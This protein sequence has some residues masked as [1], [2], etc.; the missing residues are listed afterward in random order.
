[1]STK[2]N[3][4]SMSLKIDGLTPREAALYGPQ[5][6]KVARGP[7]FTARFEPVPAEAR[8]PGWR[9]QVPGRDH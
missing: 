9:A 8:Q 4:D 7:G 3:D 2:V 6:T 5:A 1:M